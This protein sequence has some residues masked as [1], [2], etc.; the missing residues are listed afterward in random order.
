METIIGILVMA[1]LALLAT[2]VLWVPAMLGALA[3][4]N[5]FFTEVNEGTAKTI[6]KFG[7]FCRCVMSYRGHHFNDEWDL[8]DETKESGLQMKQSWIDR[9]LPGGLRYVGLPFVYKVHGYKF[10]WTSL[11]Q[12]KSPTADA[13]ATTEKGEM[14]T[15][16]EDDLIDLFI[17]R[18]E[19]IDYI[20]LMDD[21]YVFRMERA[22]D[23]E[24][25]PLSFRV[26]LTIRI[27]NP[28]KA[29][30]RTEQWLEMT[31]NT[32]RPIIKQ[33][34]GCKTFKELVL[35]RK[36]SLE[37][38]ADEILNL[39]SREE[40]AAST[41]KDYIK[42]R[43][44]V[45]IKKIGI[46]NV[47]TSGKAGEAYEESAAKKYLAEREAERITTLAGAEAGRIGILATAEAKRIQ[48]VMEQMK[49]QGSEAFTLR[50]IEA[51]EKAGENGNTILIGGDQP[52]QMLLNAAKKGKEAV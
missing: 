45:Q 30:F 46:V 39:R 27:V 26:L 22:E 17:S 6:T 28:Y 38:E 48:T 33:Y 42:G 49:V 18:D 12:G 29:L 1:G 4:R 15:V 47:N 25:I 20:N 19:K 14:S 35:D 3:K 9:K 51:M 16:K 13:A 44:G 31:I 23:R 34:V 52:V 2:S 11:R 43:W 5:L 50:T 32:L 37:H 36:E 7:E 40:G 10:R 41:I 8:L 24:M 21:V